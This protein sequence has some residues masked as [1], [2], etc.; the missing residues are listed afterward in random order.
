MDLKTGRTNSI[1]KGREE[2]TSKKAKSV[3]M[4][5]GTKADHGYCG[6]EGAVVMVKG[7]R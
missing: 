3:E 7:E 2:A 1:N 5:F 4:W 6:G